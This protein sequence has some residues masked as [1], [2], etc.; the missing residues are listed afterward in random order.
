MTAH[1]QAAP[2]LW[3]APVA[4][5][6][7]RATV[8]VPGSKSLTARHL[9]LAALADGPSRLHGALDSRDTTL[10]A[11][12]LGTLGSRIKT[13]TRQAGWQVFPGALRG[14]A[15]IDCGL[16]GTVM[17]FVPPVAALADGPI[18]FDG[19]PEARSRPMGPVLTALRA[20]GVEVEAA[21][22]TLP[23]TVR[24]VGRVRGGEIE[25]DASASSQFISGLLLAGARF[26]D[27][28]MLR[29]V[30][31]ALPSLPHI[32]MTVAVL[33]GAGVQVDDT[34]PN[35]WQ[36]APGPIRAGDIT[37]EPDLSNAAPFLAAAL[38]AG[39]SVRVPG[40]PAHS[41]QPG[42]L[43][44]DLLTSM[45]GTAVVA[46][47]A[48]TVTGTGE[49]RGIDVDLRAAGELAPTFAALAALAAGPSRL[50]GI[51]HLR[52]HETDR[53]AALAAEITALGGEATETADGLA[54]T[55]RPLHA[56]VFHTYHDHRMAT[57]G[58]LIGLRIPGI[59][60]ENITTTAKTLPG[61][62]R[63]WTDMISAAS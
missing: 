41:T 26:T 2:N 48:L 32:A 16:A 25:V 27:G 60:V 63:M 28:L 29:H 47:G 34:E 5:A 22:D 10:M 54:I 56:G 18:H 33:R 37:I 20:L 15:T 7:L 45:G 42:M 4:T 49:L 31:P 3:S 12:A 19:D 9:I 58:A 50:R 43:L 46:D 24:G 36:V 62:D 11:A 23:F 59:E 38:V 35:R 6:P 14:P 40:W 57:S 51:A 1:P 21:A 39:G 53:L 8:T 55:P 61:F 44:P 13:G 17:R 52:G 30:G